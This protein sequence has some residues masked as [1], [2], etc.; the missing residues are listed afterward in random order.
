MADL[1][2]L[3]HPPQVGVPPRLVAHLPPATAQV[4]EGQGGF[5]GV[6]QGDLQGDTQMFPLTIAAA[7]PGGD[8]ANLGPGALCR[9]SPVADPP[10]A[11]HARVPL[12]IWGE[13]GWEIHSVF[14]ALWGGGGYREK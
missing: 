3:G 10:P 12:L 2:L 1:S 14:P 8:G 5:P 11:A 13:V 9:V 7:Q 4:A 6:V